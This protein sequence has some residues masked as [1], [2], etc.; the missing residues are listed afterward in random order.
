M[1]RSRND[2]VDD[3]EAEPSDSEKDEVVQESVCES[4]TSCHIQEEEIVEVVST[5]PAA[6]LQS[7]LPRLRVC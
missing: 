7:Y 2:S 1:W 5:D 4:D 3:E 6:K